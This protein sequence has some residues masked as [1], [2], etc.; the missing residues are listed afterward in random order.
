LV[1]DFPTEVCDQL[2]LLDSLLGDM[3]ELGPEMALETPNRLVLHRQETFQPNTGNLSTIIIKAVGE[4]TSNVIQTML[5][6]P[7]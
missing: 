3:E 4:D 2:D 7:F 5:N 1:A 6:T